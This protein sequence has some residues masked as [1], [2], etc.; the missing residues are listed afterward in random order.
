MSQLHTLDRRGSA[1]DRRGSTI[2]KASIADFMGGQN[3]AA[4]FERRRSTIF[5]ANLQSLFQQAPSTSESSTETE[6]DSN[7]SGDVEIDLR[8]RK[9]KQIKNRKVSISAP[10]LVEEESSKFESSKSLKSMSSF[11]L[12]DNFENTKCTF[13]VNRHAVSSL[14][15]KLSEQAQND[16]SKAKKIKG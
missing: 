7:E 9:I 1:L 4:T 3:M 8:M 5:D 10:D 14:I 15:D 12:N 16:P 11:K 2:R 6:I 13:E